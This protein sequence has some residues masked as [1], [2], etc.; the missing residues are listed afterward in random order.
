MGLNVIK[1]REITYLSSNAVV[2]SYPVWNATTTFNT[3]DRCIYENTIYQSMADGNLNVI[4]SDDP[5]K[6][7]KEQATNPYALLD[8]RTTARTETV[9]TYVGE[10]S[11]TKSDA[12]S[13]IDVTGS[14]LTIEE[15]DE[16][17]VVFATHTHNITEVDDASGW[18]DFFLQDI[19]EES[20]TNIEQK[21]TLD[22]VQK[23]RIT[24]TGANP[25]IGFLV[26][27]RV[28]DL[29]CVKWGISPSFI[30]P[31]PPI[32]NSFGN[33][34]LVKGNFQTKIDMDVWFDTKDI[35]SIYFEFAKMQD[36]ALYFTADSRYRALKTYGYISSFVPI[37]ESENSA[38]YSLSIESFVKGDL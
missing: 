29:G 23:V 35:D 2:E 27:G 24:V 9:G 15:L 34:T 10:F 3:E 19:P 16:S 28:K 30:N 20:T 26:V 8:G 38:S 5:L 18:L 1:P 6:W 36:E 37:L 13:L 7:N 31:T 32:K 11:F 33:V 4:P 25:K 21:I 22:Q 17:D 14:V 12:L